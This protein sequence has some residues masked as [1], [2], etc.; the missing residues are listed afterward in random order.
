VIY[1]HGSDP[2]PVTLDRLEFRSALNAAGANAVITIDVDGQ[3]YLSIVKE[4]Q[5]DTIANK[6]SHVDFQLVRLDELIVVDVP[7]YLTGEALA[8]GRQ[9]A[10]VQ[11]Q[12]MSL[13]VQAPAGQIPQSFEIDI[14]ELAIETPLRVS[15]LTLPDGVISQLEVETVIAIAQIS[16]A[17]L[18]DTT[19]DELAVDG[20]EAIDGGD[21]EASAAGDSDGAGD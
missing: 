6:V 13:S 3:D 17:T 5:R 7:V 16:R 14:E 21:D 4:L 18:A 9:G 19:E 2:I 10:V 12:V 11:Q 8:A 1:G 20:D 15:D